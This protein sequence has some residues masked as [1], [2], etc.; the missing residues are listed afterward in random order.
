MLNVSLQVYYGNITLSRTSF[1][2]REGEIVTDR[3]EW[4]RQV[5]DLEYSLGLIRPTAGTIEFLGHSILNLTPQ[6]R[7]QRLAH[8]R[9]APLLADERGENLEMEPIR[10]EDV[11]IDEN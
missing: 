11:D 7:V 10:V 3:C 6:N 8:C 4:S 9:R 2:R 1:L 5:N